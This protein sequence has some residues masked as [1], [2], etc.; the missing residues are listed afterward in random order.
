MINFKNPQDAAPSAVIL[1]AIFIM[2]ATLIYGLAV[3]VPSSATLANGR[4]K[5]QKKLEGDI[6][7]AKKDAKALAQQVKARLWAE[8]PDAITAQILGK[9]TLLAKQHS[10]GVTAFRP[11]KQQILTGVTELPYNIIVTGSFP[12]VQKMA[13]EL[14]NS[15]ARLA[16]RSMQLASSDAATSAVSATLNVSAFIETKEAPAE[17]KTGAKKR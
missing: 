2:L 7:N 6:R 12:A 3:P 15:S 11:Q 17:P 9:V 10:L 14:E 8:K 1:C 5:S 13:R 16:L 4:I